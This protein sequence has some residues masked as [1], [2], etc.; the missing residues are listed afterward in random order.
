MKRKKI[1]LSMLLVGLACHGAWAN[2]V[3]VGVEPLHRWN[4]TKLQADVDLSTTDA[5]MLDEFRHTVNG[6][7]SFSHSRDFREMGGKIS[8]SYFHDC[9]LYLRGEGE[10]TSLTGDN[11]QITVLGS[12][13]GANWIAALFPA[14]NKELMLGYNT[15]TKFKGK[16]KGHNAGV[17][18]ALGYTLDLNDTVKF[19]PEF[20]YSRSRI[21]YEQ[22]DPLVNDTPKAFSA[23]TVT[24]FNSKNKLTW[25]KDDLAVAM[26][27]SWALSDSLNYGLM[28]G[29]RYSTMN[30]KADKSLLNIPELTGKYR[31]HG[32]QVGVEMNKSFFEKL[33]VGLNYNFSSVDY[34]GKKGKREIARGCMDNLPALAVINHS[35]T[36]NN[37]RGKWRV[38]EIKVGLTYLF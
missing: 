5:S 24:G 12:P 27:L 28:V 14:A 17:G 6:P 18:I 29:Y 30:H 4:K 21:R 16:S 3:E 32:F 8:L 25:N 11:K 19:I 22:K 20:S 38:H 13:T 1:F 34:K 2:S 37:P 35:Y 26:K 10:L 7:T 31:G 33:K 9:G 15:T 36:A 23:A